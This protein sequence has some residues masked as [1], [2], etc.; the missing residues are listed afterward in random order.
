MQRIIG[1][2]PAIRYINISKTASVSDVSALNIATFF[3]DL[4]TRN[5]EVL[6]GNATI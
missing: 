3:I 6:G 2:P 5:A 1:L 4:S